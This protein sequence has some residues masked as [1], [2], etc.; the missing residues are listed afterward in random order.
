MESSRARDKRMWTTVVIT[1]KKRPSFSKPFWEREKR[2]R[3][4]PRRY[5]LFRYVALKWLQCAKDV[6]LGGQKRSKK[7]FDEIKERDAKEEGKIEK[8]MCV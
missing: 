7:N 8:C 2:A 5:G 1:T 4:L 3:V 6:L